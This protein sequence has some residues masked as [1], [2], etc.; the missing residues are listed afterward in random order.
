VIR[1]P[2]C[3]LPSNLLRRVVAAILA[4]EYGRATR[5]SLPIGEVVDWGAAQRL[6]EDGVGFD[7]LMLLGAAQRVADFFG[8]REVGY[9]DYLLV[10]RT[11]GD[12]ENIVAM[13]WA[14]KYDLVTFRTSGTT[15]PSRTSAH[16]FSH[17]VREAT[18]IARLAEPF[19]RIVSFVAPH[20]IY[21]FLHTIVSAATLGVESLDLRATTPGSRRERLREGD[22]VVATPYIWDLLADETGRFPDGI[23][24]MTSTAP[25]SAALAYR[26][27]AS[28]LSRMVEIYG[29]SETSG[30]CWRDDLRAP[31]ALLPWWR[32][33][34]EDVAREDGEAVTLPDV[35]EWLDER[36]LT[37]VRRADGAVQI[38]GV[39]VYPARVAET[40]RR[41]P[42][43]TDCVVRRS[44]AQET[45]RLEA[46][47]VF[48]E[49]LD[50]DAKV[51]DIAN[52]CARELTAPERPAHIEVGARLP[53]DAMGKPTAW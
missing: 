39:N 17:M 3:P 16:P 23:V 41:H 22:L 40:I 27:A 31:Y 10:R 21:G 18:T 52:F 5:R 49:V 46:F 43:V 28:G 6:D 47:V 15:G 37:P 2:G 35:V 32:R 34:G 13:S 29:S 36:H 4:D 20:H 14:V 24:G 51:R 11:L 42:G 8:L 33:S 38:A 45:A 26:L 9:E 25:M 1:H 44:G 53:L 48:A 19:R 50:K 30:L 12:W 7:S